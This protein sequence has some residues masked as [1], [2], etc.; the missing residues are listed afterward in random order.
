MKKILLLLIVLL[1]LLSCDLET[2]YD[3]TFTNN[4][5]Y[6]IA[7]APNGQSSWTSFLLGAGTARVITIPE[8]SIYFVYTYSNY[9]N[10]NASE[11]SI[12]FTNK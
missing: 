6:D 12:T 2:E 11:S 7:I 1:S 8:D 3:Y 5:S 9:V 4:S 10:C